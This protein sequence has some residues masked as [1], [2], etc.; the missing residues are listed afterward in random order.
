MIRYVMVVLFV[1]SST[2]YSSAH[3]G[4]HHGPS[5]ADAPHGGMMKSLET[6]NIEV[7]YREK[8]VRAY[9]YDKNMKALKAKDYKVSAEVSLPRKKASALAGVT[10]KDHWRYPFDAKGAHRFTF[11]L[12]IEQGGHKDRLKWNIEPEGE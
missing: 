7:V 10:D 8:T 12:N 9:I 5:T 2:I 6:V 1:L 11:F 4:H 3:E